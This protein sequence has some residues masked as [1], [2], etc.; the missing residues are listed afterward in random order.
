MIAASLALPAANAFAQVPPAPSRTVNDIQPYRVATAADIR[1]E[2]SAA[3]ETMSTS[4][5]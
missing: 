2:K 4:S 3:I 5:R 1:S